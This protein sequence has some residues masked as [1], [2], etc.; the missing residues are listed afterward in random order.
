MSTY[1]VYI[2]NEPIFSK[3]TRE[4]SAN[5]ELVGQVEATN[6]SHALLLAKRF[7]EHP[8]IEFKQIK[9]SKNVS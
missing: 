7:T 2:Q 1:N 9:G 8:V 3:K 5:F 6:S 4:Y